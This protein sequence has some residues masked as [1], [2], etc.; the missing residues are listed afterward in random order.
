MSEVVRLPARGLDGLAF[1]PYGEVLEP[2][3]SLRPYF[4]SGRTSVEQ[5]RMPSGALGPQIEQL[6]RHDSYDQ[7]FAQ[8]EG[9]LALVVAPEPEEGRPLVD[10][11]RTVAFVLEPG[12]VVMVRRGAW[13]T[14][15]PLGDVTFVNVTRRDDE[16]DLT[17]GESGRHY[18][19]NVNTKERD[20]RILQVEDPSP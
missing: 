2:R 20:G 15:V 7:V 19:S 10:Y 12:D 13:H 9:R 11:D 3:G 6:A 16:E 4:G 5:V 17:A 18:I 1:T 8:V 14:V